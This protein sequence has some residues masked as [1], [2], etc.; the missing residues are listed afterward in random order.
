LIQTTEKGSNWKKK[1]KVYWH[2]RR[3]RVSSCYSA[4]LGCVCVCVCVLLHYLLYTLS[5]VE[6]AHSP[7]RKKDTSSTDIACN[8]SGQGSALLGGLFLSKCCR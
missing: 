6:A 8:N 2:C 3:R 7:K 4:P 1:K 5:Q